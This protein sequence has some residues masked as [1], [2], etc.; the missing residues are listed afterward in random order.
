MAA[1]EKHPHVRVVCGESWF[2]KVVEKEGDAS[3]EVII[4]HVRETGYKLTTEPAEHS[5]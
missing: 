4:E 5:E 2:S 1:D 3:A